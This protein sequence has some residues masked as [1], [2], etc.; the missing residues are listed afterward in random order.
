MRS[1]VSISVIIRTINRGQR[2]REAL[3]SLVHQTQRNFEAVIV[4]M[5]GGHALSIVEDYYDRLPQIQHL[6][7]GKSLF[8]S[9]ALNQG[10][11]SAVADKIAILDD[12]NLYDPSHLEVLVT[13]LEQTGA[14]L[15][16]TGVRRTTY[17]PANQLIDVSEWHDPFDF[18]RLVFSNYIHTSGTAFFKRTWERL[19]GY[20]P[21]FP[22]YEDCDFLLR[23]GAT[24]RIQC[25]PAVTAE[26]RS[27]TG[28]PG[29]QNHFGEP[30]ANRCRAGIYWLHR[31]LLTPE[32]FQAH[33]ELLRSK[34][35]TGRHLI[36]SWTEWYLRGRMF[37]DLPGWWFY[38]AWPYRNGR[39]ITASH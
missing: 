5:S 39:K 31:K 35:L 8:R 15:V 19:D 17:T 24:G 36:N 4:D 27:F 26:S 20:D 21:R 1:N 11:R 32:R 33:A 7:I 34:G 12:D 38:H 37:K 30:S 29:I 2:L 3:E 22:V 18:S 28:K 9:E 14:D 10:I 23:L 25:L 13:G 16:Y 6:Q